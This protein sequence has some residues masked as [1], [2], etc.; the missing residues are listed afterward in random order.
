MEAEQQDI[1]IVA[2]SIPAQFTVT[3]QKVELDIDFSREARGRTE[4][5]IYPDTKDLKSI[6]LHSKQCQIHNVLINGLKPASIIHEDPCGQMYLHTESTVHQHHILASKVR[7]EFQVPPEAS[8]IIELPRRLRIEP[9]NL[10][11]V[12]TQNAG[13]IRISKPD[14]IPADAADNTQS[15]SDTTVAIFTPL[16]VSLEFSSIHLRDVLHFVSANPGSGRWPHVYTR[17]GF[18]GG[19]ASCLFPCIDTIAS[20]CTWEI[21]IKSA[22][23]VRDAIR[24]SVGA[25]SLQETDNSNA[26]LAHE[27]RD[28]VFVC[29][30]EVTDEIIDKRDP[31]KKTVIFS[32]L[33][34][35]S[36]QQIGFAIGPFERVNLSE[37]RDAQEIE[38]LGKNAVEMIGYCLPGR[39]EEVKNTCLP[40]TKAMD[41]FVKK[42]IAC[43]Y[44]RFSMCFIEDQPPQPGIFAEVAICG[45][46]LLYPENVIDTAKD[47]TRT[48]VHTIASQWIGVNIIA[49]EPQDMWVIIGTSYLITDLFMRDLCGN[50][51]YRYRM[52]T[53]SDRI[54]ELDQERPSLHD[55]GTILHID[56]SE[57]E[58]MALKAPVVLFVLDR[59]MAKVTGV[60][61][62]PAVIAKILTRARTDELK[63]NVLSTDYFQKM[64]E[65]FYHQRIDDFMAQWVKGAGCPR[66][67][68]TQRFNKKKLV[69]EMMIRQ[70]QAQGMGD[71]ELETD[72]FMRDVREDFNTVYA[73]E[74]QRVFTGPMTIRIHEADGTPYEHIVDIKD[75]TTTVD[76][77]YNTKYKRLKRT[78][79]QK[80]R[81]AAKAQEA[82]DDENDALLY[83][84]GDVLQTEEDVASWRLTDWTVEDEERMNAESYEWI[85]L[86]ADFEWICNIRLQMPGY[87]FASQLQQDRDVAA[88]L[89]SIQHIN[90]YPASPLI[91]TI[92]LRTMMDSRYFHGIRTT[93][94][95]CLVKHATDEG[96]VNNIGLYHLMKAFEVLYCTT[97]NGAKMTRPNDFSNQLSYYLQNALIDAISSIRDKNGNTPRDVKEFLLDKLRFNDNSLNDYSDAF[98]ISNIIRGLTRAIIARPKRPPEWEMNMEIETEFLEMNQLEKSCLDEIDRYRRMDEWTSS[99][100]NMYSRTVLECQARLSKAGIGTFSPLHFLQYTRPGNYDMLRITAYNVLTRSK[101]FENPSIL[102]YILH[103]IVADSSPYIRESLRVFFG[104]ALAVKAI[105][106]ARVEQKG[107]GLVIEDVNLDDK[108]NEKL[109]RQTIEGSM[110]ALRK[111]LGQHKALK[112]YLWN[113]VCHPEIG[114]EDLKALL[115]FC[116]LLYEPIDTARVILP[117]PRYWKVQA[118]GKGKLKFSRTNKVRRKPMEKWQPKAKAATTVPEPTVTRPIKLKL[119]AKPPI[120]STT[121]TPPPNIISRPP[122]PPPQQQSSQDSIPKPTSQKITLKLKR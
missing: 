16:T 61:K 73:A 68:A 120:S 36:P 97:D 10:A 94:A 105:G 114:Y 79:R 54:V 32:C 100:Q 50:N 70:V 102:R 27:E 69:I 90:N 24:Q 83:C 43:P 117:L 64:V 86:D 75:G 39:T 57:Y 113:A 99:Y 92:L 71:R 18:G 78:K 31:T 46:R 33:D 35:L 26:D 101:L 17:T 59:R 4:I 118:L 111:E 19:R 121:P 41:Y 80:S 6:S 77:P 63:D 96:D 76:I 48:L 7:S 49:E 3:H 11:E 20:R 91:S 88:Q 85:R 47:V 53:L 116:K 40:T 8:L 119:S 89:I 58:F 23:T 65:K 115:E 93:A 30:G 67:Q 108:E 52:K 81:A 37:F 5:I 60:S 14:N 55:M 74:P 112:T 109:R 1:P 22:R 44:L 34:R 21:S 84:L 104:K 12:H 106:E 25:K 122:P 15:L 95:S 98:Y 9:V 107:D 51:E 82:G 13:M 29:T 87:M 45:T 103:C 2:A 72:T 66:F 38:E 62:M 28:M 56:P 42:Y 110:E